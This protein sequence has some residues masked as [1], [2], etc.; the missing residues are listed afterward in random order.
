MSRAKLEQMAAFGNNPP[1][2][3]NDDL[4][5]ETPTEQIVRSQSERDVITAKTRQRGVFN[6]TNLKLQVLTEI[7]GYSQRWFN[8]EPGR[9]DRALQGGWEFVNTGEVA[10]PES[11]K[12]ISNNASVDGRIT[13]IAGVMD[14]NTA[15]RAYLMK[16]KTEWLEEDRADFTKKVDDG[17]RN[18]V[19]GQGLNTSGIGPT[20]LPDG[21]TKA[22]DIKRGEFN[23]A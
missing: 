11:N 16:I 19:K 13:A 22:L 12:V 9:L 5:G 15:L 3:N 1:P 23:R 21:K 10:Q 14:N 20:Y 2:S 18:M 17:E 4:M 7:P 8:D 6:G